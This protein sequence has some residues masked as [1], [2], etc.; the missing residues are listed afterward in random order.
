MNGASIIRWLRSARHVPD[1]VLH[2]IRRR[3]VIRRLTTG[4]ACQGQVLFIC[5]GNV[6]RSPFAE[7]LFKQRTRPAGAST[8]DF[9]TAS[10]GF[11]GPD[12]SPPPEALAAAARV[13]VN[14]SAHRSQLVTEELLHASSLIVV[15]SAA[16]AATIRSTYPRES[17]KLLVLGDLDPLPIAT[18]TVRDPWNGSAMVFDESYERIDRCVRHLVS[19]VTVSVVDRT[20]RGESRHRMTEVS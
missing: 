15:M 10:A 16:Q 5:H 11:V 3:A 14:L 13:G 18:R 2:P 20:P 9:T 6:C 8:S 1:R 19:C 12:R 4:P 7:A 17:P